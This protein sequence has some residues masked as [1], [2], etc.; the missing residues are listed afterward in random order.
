MMAPVSVARSIMNLRLEPRVD[1]VQHVG[2]HE[3]ALGVG[4]DDLDRLAGHG[5][6]DVARPLRLAVRHVLDQPDRADA[7]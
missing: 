7:H 3:P 5:L 4:V 6:D 2:E 1:V